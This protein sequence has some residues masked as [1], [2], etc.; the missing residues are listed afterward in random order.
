MHNIMHMV[1][2]LTGLEPKFTKVTRTKSLSLNFPSLPNIHFNPL[3]IIFFIFTEQ[4]VVLEYG[5]CEYV[6][7]H[8]CVCL[9]SRHPF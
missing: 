6:H 1:K 4:N 5:I 9:Q 3:Y 7:L 2:C 8:V